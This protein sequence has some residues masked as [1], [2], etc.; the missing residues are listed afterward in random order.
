MSWLQV[1][2]TSVTERSSWRHNSNSLARTLRFSG[3]ETS[4]LA[5]LLEE[6]QL[7]QARLVTS[8]KMAAVGG[9]VAGVVHEINSPLGVIRSSSHTT[10]RCA[11]RIAAT[12]AESRIA[13][14]AEALKASSRVISEATERIEAL[15]TRL[16]SFAGIDRA[17]YSQFDLLRGLDDVIALL[18][19]LLR[20]RV[21]VLRAYR[22]LPRIYCYAAE[23]SQV[24]MHL[25]RNAAHAIDGAGEITIRTDCD[26][27]HIRIAVIDTGRGIPANEIPNLFSPSFNRQEARVKASLSLFICQSI[28]HNHGGDIHVS[29]TPGKGS[30][31]TLVLPRALENAVWK[32]PEVSSLSA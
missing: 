13:P 25:L 18:D 8:E 26:T 10:V 24:F 3:S 23:I 4:E 31:F 15:V 30:T 12:A 28:T 2:R 7:T 27:T 17:D 22:E 1:T 6:L 29:S 32:Q 11:E 19:P 21:I 16:K 20:G 5:R 14:L 9:L